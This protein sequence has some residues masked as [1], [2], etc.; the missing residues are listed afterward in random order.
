[1]ERYSIEIKDLV[2]DYGE[3]IAVNKINLQVKEGEL[4]TLLG[5]SGCGKSTTLNALAGLITPTS[6]DI[7]FNGRNVTKLSPKERNIGLVFQSYALYPHMTVYKNI[8][9][10]LESSKIFKNSI[11]KI[12]AEIEREAKNFV[13]E[14][15][16]EKDLNNLNSV[17]DNFDKRVEDESIRITNLENDKK[18]RIELINK[19]IQQETLRKEGRIKSASVKSLEEI[20]WLENHALE[21]KNE[22]NNIKI[23]GKN[24]E[25]SQKIVS[26]IEEMIL[27][28]KEKIN[29]ILQNTSDKIQ[30]IKTD[31][32][33]E[34]NVIKENKS[35]E[36]K[37][38]E[39][40]F[41]IK[42]SKAKD[43][44]E[45]FKKSQSNNYKS[46]ITKI[47]KVFKIQI[48]NLND[49]QKNQYKN[50]LGKRVNFKAEIDRKVREVAEIVGITD[51][52]MKRV[53]KLSGGQQQR[54]A[55][56]RTLVK[57]PD[58]LLLDEPLSN[59][60][61]K[62]RVSTREWIRKLQQKLGI[63]TIFVTHDQ[64]EAMSI[65]D[66]I[67]CMSNGHIQQVEEPME[68]YHNPTNKFV[69]GFLGMPQMN[70]FDE[71]SELNIKLQK[72]Y[73]L[74]DHTFGIRPEHIR[75]SSELK[76]KSDSS[77][78]LEGIITLIESFGRE[79]L[80]T[81]KIGNESIRLFTENIK[82]K[83]GNKTKINFR[84]GKLY[85][86]GKDNFEKVTIKK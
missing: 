86:F 17:I 80:L 66:R 3:S 72:K 14:T 46:S 6:G 85:C 26:D 32:N 31:Y 67:V 55:I 81:I 60:D 11:K 56:S 54:V 51:Q 7:I 22:I 25:E 29:L 27:N 47:N 52:L 41:D 36:I 13:Y 20:E 63:T 68:M 9:F 74:K 44:L 75:I 48:K 2:I 19:R 43:E 73:K 12:N 82:L 15:S 65:S 78:E 16:D 37:D 58:I 77:M 24:T 57:N 8:A 40:E 49:E 83:V 18:N 39:N 70:F 71:K 38:I 59:L 34:V 33:S 69:A 23:K 42:I 84:K 1:M 4:V 53:T 62:M 45:E 76:T 64:E 30:K 79:R 28:T 61:A 50:I 10:P 35:N 21:L 5:P